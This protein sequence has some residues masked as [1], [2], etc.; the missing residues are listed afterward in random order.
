MGATGAL[1]VVVVVVLAVTHAAAAPPGPLCTN[2][3]GSWCC[4]A[5]VVVQRGALLTST[6]AYGTG[7]GTIRGAD[8]TMTFSNSAG[9]V[10]GRVMTPDCACIRVRMLRPALPPAPGVPPASR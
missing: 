5:T 4:E 10:D 9:L 6:A 7:N 1:A 8:I 3:T 2:L